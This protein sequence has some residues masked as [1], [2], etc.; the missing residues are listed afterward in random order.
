MAV[1][2]P[3]SADIQW[4]DAAVYE[5][6]NDPAGPVGQFIMYLDEKAVTVARAAVH[7]LPGT[8]RSG[9][10]FDSSTA[11]RPPGTTRSSIRTHGPVIGSRG[12]LYGGGNAM[13]TGIFLE[14]DRPHTE[15]MYDRYPFMTTGLAALEAEFG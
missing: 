14:Y 10:W 13:Y 4:D 8:R 7:V 2:L 12:G 1:I 15:Q 6:L 9:Y 3:G 11:V 5:L